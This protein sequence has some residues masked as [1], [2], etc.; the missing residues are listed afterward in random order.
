MKKYSLKKKLILQ[1]FLSGML[2]AILAL[3]GIF[4]LKDT[5]KDVSQEELPKAQISSRLIAQFRSVR[6]NARSL[7]VQGNT[8]KDINY[9]KKE[10]LKAVAKFEEEK[11][12][13]ER[14][15]FTDEERAYVLKMNKGWEAFYLFA[16]DLLKQYESPTEESLKKGADM[17]RDICPVKAKEWMSVAE[18]FFE[19]TSE[20]NF[21]KLNDAQHRQQKNSNYLFISLA[22]AFLIVFIQGWYFSH[23]LSLH[24]QKYT[25][26]LAGSSEEIGS[27]SNELRNKSSML[28]DSSIKA[29][30]SLQETV[31]SVDEISSMIN[32]NT[33]STQDSAKTSE[34]SKR[35]ASQGLETMNIMMESIENIAANSDELV[36]EMNVNNKNISEILEVISEISEKTKVINDIVFQTKL[37][38]FNASVE[39]ARAGEHGKGFAVVAEEVGSLAAMSGTAALEIRE[40]LDRSISQVTQIVNNTKAKMEILESSS[41]EKIQQGNIRAKESL[42]ALQQI[43]RDIDEVDNLIGEIS[44]ASQ[45]QSLG[46]QEVSKAMQELDQLTHENSNIAQETSTMAENFKSKSEELS[47]IVYELSV[48]VYG[49]VET[50]TSSPLKILKS[51]SEDDIGPGPLGTAA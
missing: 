26:F 24:I 22:F 43:L 14:L 50:E 3:T 44:T 21:N 8:L 10:T 41:K 5:F 4:T 9:Y 15:S 12:K 7:A 13:F 25:S 31:S 2:L 19:K 6:I 49:E 42:E 40:M 34:K 17:I 46:V 38:S 1:T 29:A 30:S 32:K 27:Y 20:S 33:R 11:S 18:E 35:T 45:E 37:L 47:E 48:L 51:E 23:R 36:E 16:K 39:A 28:T